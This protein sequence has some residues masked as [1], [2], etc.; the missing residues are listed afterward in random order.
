MSFAI[1][2]AVDALLDAIEADN[3]NREGWVSAIARLKARQ[4][5]DAASWL[6]HARQGSAA[7]VYAAV[8][9]REQ[10]DGVF[11]KAGDEEA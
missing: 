3:A 1:D 6:Y 8:A 4:I 2:R 11:G 9:L 10:V 7:S 5:L